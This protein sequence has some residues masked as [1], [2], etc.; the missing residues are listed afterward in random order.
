MHKEA[1]GLTTINNFICVAWLLN[2][3]V[4][5]SKIVKLNYFSV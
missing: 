4:L 1:E 5:K 3:D 2:L